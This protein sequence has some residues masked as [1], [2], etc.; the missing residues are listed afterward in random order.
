VSEG[1]ERSGDRQM[2]ESRLS[3]LR[4]MRLLLEEARVL[5]CDLAYH[6]R[7]RLEARGVFEFAVSPAILG[8]LRSK[9][10]EPKFR[11]SEAEL[12]RVESSIGD[13][14][15]VVEREASLAV[16]E[17][18]PDNRILEY[19]VTSGASAIVTGDRHLLGRKTYEGIGIMT[20]AELL[21][22]FP[23]TP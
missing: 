20:V 12:D 1:P 9:L 23:E 2:A 13:A 5:S 6:R 7:V 17:D 3:E 15:T 14:A 21:C 4:N 19:A 18:E 8:E 16:L 22:T 11:F 10:S